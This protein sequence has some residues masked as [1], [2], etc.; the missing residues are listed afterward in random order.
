MFFVNSYIYVNLVHAVFLLIHI[1][2]FL[3]CFTLVVFCKG[4]LVLYF[5]VR[6]H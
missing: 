6:E 4:G 5:I 2:L 3:L 1:E